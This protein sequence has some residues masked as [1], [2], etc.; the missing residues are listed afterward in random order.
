MILAPHPIYL[1]ACIPSPLTD[2]SIPRPPT[3]E[4][5]PPQAQCARDPYLLSSIASALHFKPNLPCLLAVCS[6]DSASS[7]SSFCCYCRPANL[8][9]ALATSPAT[10]GP[11]QVAQFRDRLVGCGCGPFQFF[12]LL[13]VAN[14]TLLLCLH[15]H[16]LG[17][18]VIP[19]TPISSCWRKVSFAT[20][21]FFFNLVFFSLHSILSYKWYCLPI[22]SE[23]FSFFF[24]LCISSFCF[25]YPFRA[26]ER[27]E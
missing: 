19:Y 27:V 18:R 7:I 5:S 9:S 14:E 6:A 16:G 21:N 4:I 24:N 12:F 23:G 22:I 15:G 8:S 26:S 17:G 25:L 13:L 1:V 3:L 10:P 11:L 20:S 2:W